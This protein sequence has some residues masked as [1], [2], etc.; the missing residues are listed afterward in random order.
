MLL[1]LLYL[2]VLAFCVPYVG[3]WSHAVVGKV[4]GRLMDPFP[5][6]IF[7]E[8]Y[9]EASHTAALSATGRKHNT[10]IVVGH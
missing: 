4:A 3:A 6:Q 7:P 5:A 10:R 9:V 2:G 1:C 8:V